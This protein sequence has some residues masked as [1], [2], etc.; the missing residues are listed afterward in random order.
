MVWCY[1]NKNQQRS[2]AAYGLGKTVQVL[3]GTTIAVV[4]MIQILSFGNTALF[5]G[6]INILQFV[7]FYPI[8]APYYTTEL[9]QFMRFFWISLFD[10]IVGLWS[11]YH[12]RLKNEMISSK[13]FKPTNETFF[14]YYEEGFTNNAFLSNV[15]NVGFIVSVSVVFAMGVLALKAVLFTIKAFNNVPAAFEGGDESDEV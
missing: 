10:F 6:S 1:P 4:F 3:L 15:H 5:W 14:N 9:E 12:G 13:Y 2:K 8:A 7:A 11:E